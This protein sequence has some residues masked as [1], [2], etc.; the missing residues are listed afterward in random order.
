MH[1]GQ[2]LVDVSNTI[3]GAEYQSDESY[4]ETN[5]EG[6]KI[7][8]PNSLST[9]AKNALVPN[10]SSEDESENVLGVKRRKCLEKKENCEC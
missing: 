1:N 6:L 2:P 7:E 10:S 8:Q 3:G 4:V 5:E 9:R